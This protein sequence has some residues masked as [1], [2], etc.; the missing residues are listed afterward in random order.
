MTCHRPGSG[1]TRAPR[2]AGLGAV[3]PRAA[4]SALIVF[5]LGYLAEN[6][7]RPPGRPT[8]GGGGYWARRGA[9]VAVMRALIAMLSWL[10]FLLAGA[11]GF[12]GMIPVGNYDAWTP[13][14]VLICALSSAG[15][16]G[17]FFVV[18]SV[19]LKVSLPEAAL[20]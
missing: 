14:C 11:L 8:L 4:A 19:L 15:I 17:G 7:F 13:R 9:L 5:S 20:F 3:F 12:L 2:T 6:L 18:F 10:G 1:E 16:I